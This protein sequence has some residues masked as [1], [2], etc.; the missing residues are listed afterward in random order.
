MV[1]VSNTLYLSLQLGMHVGV[2]SIFMPIACR[3]L[4][5]DRP[6]SNSISGG[7]NH[8]S[9]PLEDNHFYEHLTASELYFCLLAFLCAFLLVQ[10]HLSL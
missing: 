8:V 3:P 4:K 6:R 1:L 9:F 10:H 5:T 2:T 7:R